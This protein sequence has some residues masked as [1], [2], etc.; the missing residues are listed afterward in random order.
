[1]NSAT[2]AQRATPACHLHPPFPPPY[3]IVSS[4]ATLA[5]RA[6]S[7]GHLR[8]KR[9]LQRSKRD[10]RIDVGHTSVAE[11]E[12]HF[13]HALPDLSSIAALPVEDDAEAATINNVQRIALIPLPE[14]SGLV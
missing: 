7:A 5:R 12:S 8:S 13:S 6:A 14:D 3:L 10:L 2:L 9:D 4:L 1:M 11:R